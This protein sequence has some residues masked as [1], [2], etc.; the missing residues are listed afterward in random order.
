MVGSLAKTAAIAA[1]EWEHFALMTPPP[2]LEAMEAECTHLRQILHVHEAEMKA[3]L[4]LFSSARSVNVVLT[5][6]D[7]PRDRE[8][9][10]VVSPPAT[11]MVAL[12]P[13]STFPI[14][15]SACVLA[16]NPARV[17][18]EDEVVSHG[19]RSSPPKTP[20][21]GKN[22][23]SPPPNLM[24]IHLGLNSSSLVDKKR[25][26]LVCHRKETICMWRKTWIECR[27]LFHQR[28]WGHQRQA[29]LP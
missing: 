28:T 18:F 12:P 15:R 17:H 11:T 13:P 19:E 26:K 16:Q 27:T 23:V 24:T 1:M 3:E 29:L 5:L 21:Q 9:V 14:R 2:T 10:I 25:R 20:K 6:E 8:V 4:L 7:L 22:I